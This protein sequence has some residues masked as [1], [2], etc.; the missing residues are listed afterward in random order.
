MA[1]TALKPCRFAGRD[2]LVG[3]SVPDEVIRPG[4]EKDLV[5]MNVLAPQ[6]D[7]I[8]ADETDE[9][10]GPFCASIAVV[11]SN[12]DTV[13]LPVTESDLQAIFD[14]LT[15]TASLA[16]PIIATMDNEYALYL[17]SLS[18]NRKSIKQA[19]KDRARE[20]TNEGE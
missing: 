17:L 1:Y 10:D 14:V 11:N 13:Y 6:P 12:G 3:E 2:Y 18:D 7:T 16:D 20:L 9:T 8:V 4:A 19:A 5:K 15:G